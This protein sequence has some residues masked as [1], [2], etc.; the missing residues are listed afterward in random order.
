MLKLISIV[1]AMYAVFEEGVDAGVVEFQT[2]ELLED[3]IDSD[4]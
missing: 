1:I 2:N 4:R 3:S